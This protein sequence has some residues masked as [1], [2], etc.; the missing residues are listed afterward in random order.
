MLITL[1]VS[2]IALSAFLLFFI[3]GKK[4]AAADTELTVENALKRKKWLIYFTAVTA[5]LLSG[6]LIGY[7]HDGSTQKL[8][9]L[10]Q[11]HI[12]SIN[13]LILSVGFSTIAGYTLALAYKQKHEQSRALSLACGV[14]IFVGIVTF[15][16]YF[17]PISNTLGPQQTS[18]GV[19]LQSHNSTCAAA[20][21]A[22]IAATYS[23]ELTERQAAE[24][25]GTSD[26]G[27]SGGQIRYAIA[28]VGLHYT[29]IQLTERDL[30]RV[31]APAM[32][33]IDHPAVGEEGHAV[34]YMGKTPQGFEI[35]DPLT[36]KEFWSSKDG[37]SRWRGKGIEISNRQ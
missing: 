13:W 15:H 35:W 20:S 7:L 36:G 23:I 34:S 26:M 25:L 19:I 24:L 17:A 4:A 27:S 28:Q 37:V 14:L 30:S 9:L 6:T 21:L 12:G 2:L 33:F 16:R 29:D 18:Q 3:I 22:N 31:E 11:R 32:L 8:P 1:S 5:L 10:L